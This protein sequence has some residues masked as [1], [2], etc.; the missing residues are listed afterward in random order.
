M[1]RT[2]ER[3]ETRSVALLIGALDAFLAAVLVIAALVVGTSVSWWLDSGMT[4]DWVSTFRNAADIWFAMHGVALNFTSSTFGTLDIPAFVIASLP[5]GAALAIFGLGWRSGKRLYGSNELWPAWVGATLVYGAISALML[6]LSATNELSA[7]PVGAYFLPALVYVSGVACG[8]LFGSLPKSAV[9]LNHAA[10]RVAGRAWLENLSGR[11]NWVLRSLASPALRAGTGFVF[12]MQAIAGVVLALLIGFNWLGV[13]QLYEQLQ[14]GVFG[15][16]G[17]TMLQLAY[18]PNLTYFASTWFSG[19]GFAIGTGSSVS[20]LGTALGPI[21][22]VPV[23]G[24][25]PVGESIGMIVLLVPILVALLVTINVKKYTAEARHNFATP[26]S[27]SIAMGLS[28]GLVA[29]TEMA[30]LA[31]IT[32]M[33]IGPGRMQNIGA[34]PLWVFVWIFLEVAPIAFV[35]SFYAAKPTAASP[36][37]EHLKR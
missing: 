20:P 21:P 28:I 36:I 34:D 25:I 27:A 14:G 1:A 35:A 30:I 29:A 18:L 33:S 26:L 9:K 6:A 2:A 12:V 3:G 24:A 19:V 10:E 15:G 7:D 17:S 31:L 8:S 4:D 5:L 22:T 32:H 11:V 16:L 37:P 23:F 13:I